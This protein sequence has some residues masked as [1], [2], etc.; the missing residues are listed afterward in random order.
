MRWFEVRDGLAV[1]VEVHGGYPF[2]F[3]VSCLE[4]PVEAVMV[5]NI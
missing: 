4:P 5:V 2:L 1:F 3:G